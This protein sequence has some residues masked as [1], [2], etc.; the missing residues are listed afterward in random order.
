VISSSVSSPVIRKAPRFGFS[1]LAKKLIVGQLKHLHTGSLTI[2]EYQIQDQSD[3]PKLVN[4]FHFGQILDHDHKHYAEIHIHD[5]SSYTDIMLAG[6]IGAAEAYMTGDWT[7][8]DLTRVIRVMVKNM[9][10]LDDMEGGLATL[11]R[12]FLK[13]FHKL[14]QN[15]EK[16]S[17][18]NIAAHYDLGND[19]FEL[20]LD[21]TMMYSSGIFPNPQATMEEASL[22]K[23]H[24]ICEKLQLTP[25][26]HVIEIGTGWGSFAIYAAKHYGCQVTT[27]TISEQQF[28]YAQKRISEE[29]L[30]N[31]ITLLMSDYRD[32]E[33]HYDK[34]VSIEMIEAV[35][36][37]YFPTFFEKCSQLLK[38]DGLMLMQ[39]IT[40]D[41]GRYE[42]ALKNVDFIQRYIFPGSC[43]PS[44]TALTKAASQVSDLRLMHMEDFADHY[45]ETLKRWHQDFNEQLVK[46]RDLGYS[47]EFIRMWQ[48][49]LSYCEGGF[50]EK[51]I[52][53]SHLMYSHPQSSFEWLPLN[54]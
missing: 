46:V 26:D 7:T 6:S 23:L 20:F 32:L 30:E 53:V 54:A 44:V 47:E 39:A 28:K 31:K 51:T 24:T 5:L 19:L 2:K 4:E 12:P 38:T 49:Y 43:I 48:F 10:L 35:G 41:E 11:S 29:G 52:G 45:G 22:H 34:L 3:S 17:K 27:T 8:P 37:K 21:P 50:R 1:Q 18:R 36:H 14:N 33:G 42:Q 9:D 13:W 40:I 25:Q 16:G 15:T